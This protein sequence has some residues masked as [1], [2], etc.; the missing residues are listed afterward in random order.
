MKSNKNRKIELRFMDLTIKL[1]GSKS[2]E[3]KAL[4]LLNAMIESRMK[5]NEIMNNDLEGDQG[6]REIP[7]KKHIEVERMFN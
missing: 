1:E 6:A 3:A 4:G 5:V 7:K 2:I